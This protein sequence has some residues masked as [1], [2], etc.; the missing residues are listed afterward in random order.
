MKSSELTGV[1]LDW[2]VAK[3]ENP[4]WWGDG[5][6]DGPMRIGRF[7]RRIAS[8]DG[9]TYSPST[10]WAQGGPII[11][12]ELLAL[13]HDHNGD[14]WTWVATTAPYVRP[15][16]HGYGPTPLISAM[17]CFVASKLG[18]EIDVPEGLI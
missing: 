14:K 10:D 17:R 3:I 15:T 2:A 4:E 5:Y 6:M 13:T 12:R 18:E 1:A 9:G 11:E 7:K 16:K 8:P